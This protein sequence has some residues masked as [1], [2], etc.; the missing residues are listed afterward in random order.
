MQ[1]AATVLGVLRERGRRGLPCSELYRQLF[2]PQLYLLAYGRIYANHGAMTPGVTQET[3]DGMS[4]RKIARI[5]EAVRH[6]RYRFRPVRRIQ[7]PKKNGKMRPL[8]ITTWSDKLVGE[9]V[10]LLLETYYEPTFSD[11][12]HGFRPRRGCHTALCEV[13]QTWT[14]TAWFIE[15]DIA[16]C[17]GSLDHQVLLSILGEKIHDRRFL[18]LV[19]NMLTA[20][21]LEDW[22]WG[23]TLSGAPQGGVASPVLSNIYLHKL[24]EFVETVLIPEYTRGERRARNPAYLE[25]ANLL[26]KARRRGDRAQAR[27]LRQRMTSLSSADPNDPHY[28][29]LRYI[30]YADDHLFGFTG[31]KAE[32]ELIKLRLAAFLHDELKLELSQ[33][34][35]LITHARTRAARFLG[36]VITVQHNDTK[37]TGRY[38]RVN[39]RI[40]LR[41]PLDVIKAKSVPYL[42]RGKPAKRKDLVNSSVHAIVAT[43]GSVYRGIVQYY[44][45]AGDV[46]R[47]HRLRWVMETSMLKTLAAKHRSSVPKMAAKHKTRI[48]TDQGARVCFEAR[49]ERKNRKPLVARFGGIPLY[50]QRSAKIVDRRPVWVDYPHKELVTRL[51]ADICEICGSTGDV[52]VHHIRALADLAHAGWLPSDWARVMLDRRRKT[53][54]ACD[55]CHDRIHEAQTARSFTP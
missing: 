27:T 14:G 49:I 6:E 35:T 34:K 44:L 7:I 41:V 2:N 40:A 43:F 9:V 46:S 38:R 15:A 5:I 39:G 47:L 1:S 25:L 18:R 33:E 4:Q 13:T 32:A 8:G 37:K 21:Y 50:R 52:T 12:S 45:L 16:D 11:R 20:G 31:P 28:R 54:V 19:R 53:V 36:Y 24:D 42:A 29:R 30:R 3:V 17:F 55:T 26:A 22:R 51:L 23:A 10:R 48:D